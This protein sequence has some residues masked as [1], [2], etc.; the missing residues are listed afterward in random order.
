MDRVRALEILI[1][2]AD[3]GGFARAGVRLGMSPPAVTRAVAALEDRLGVRLLTRTTRKVRLTEAGVRLIDSSRRVIAEL[4]AAE[5]EASGSTVEPQGHLSLTA[6]VALGRMFLTPI[7]SAFL[8]AHGKVTASLVLLDRIVD[9]I[10]EGFDIGVRIGE[11]SNSSLIASRVGAVGRVLIASPDYLAR[12][13]KP[14][15]PQD[16]KRHAMIG[17]TGLMPSPELR[18]LDAGHVERVTVAPRLTVNDA[19]AALAAA[20]AGEG[21]AP[22]LSYMVAPQLRSGRLKLVL[23]N[24]QPPPAP[25]HL[26]YPQGLM[27]ASKVR[28]FIDFA[29]PRLARALDDSV[30]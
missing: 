21:I 12:H 25:V 22:A 20:E 3:A 5:Q 15:A 11:L 29:R 2:I 4:D 19:G 28:A 1:A 14:R 7:T 26:V 6:S 9:L 8:A 10:E 30:D 24:A 16:L 27:L 13:G 17:F 18:L 23:K